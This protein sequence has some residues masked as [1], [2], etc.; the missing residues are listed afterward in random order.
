[1]SRLKDVAAS[2]S[3]RFLNYAREQKYT[4][5][6]ALQYP[7]IERFLYRLAQSKY[8][9]IFVLKGVLVFAWQFP[10]RSTTRD[11]NLHGRRPDTIEHPKVM[12]KENCEQTVQPDGMLFEVKNIKRR[13]FRARG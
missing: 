13:D 1:M 11:I 9:D 2:I 10:L 7:T 12:V 6:G 8:R 3:P 4:Y 5:Q